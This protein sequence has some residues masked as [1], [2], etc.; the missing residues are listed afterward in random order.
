MRPQ[1]NP[2]IVHIAD[3]KDVDLLCKDVNDTAKKLMEHFWPGPLTL[4]LNKKNIVP[5][6]V[7]CGLDSVGI[8]FPSH[9]LAL[10]IIKSAGVPLA[11]PSANLSG[12]PS[13]TNTQHVYDDL[14]H[15][16][17]A[18]VDGGECEI[19][20][21]STV[22]DVRSDT[23]IILRPGKISLEQLR[24]IAPNTQTADFNK[25]IEE[26]TPVFS[27]G[28]KYTHYA[29]KAALTLVN[30]RDSEVYAYINKQIKSL[31]KNCGVMCFTQSTESFDKNAVIKSYGN[32]DDC[33]DLASNLFKILREFDDTDVKKIYVQ[34]PKSSFGIGMAVLNRLLKASG[35]DIITLTS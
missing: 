28:M 21:E 16:I 8:R 10:S 9:P 12:R 14:N 19:G 27:P 32:K 15:R 2:L 30:G 5:D 34:L 4:I 18:I 17:D 11:A 7:S 31:G 13:P 29:P 35:Y 33:N 22:V 23:P 26:D 24:E 6:I 20:L 1:D 3:I 25:I